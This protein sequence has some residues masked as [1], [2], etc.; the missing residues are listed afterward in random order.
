MLP[1]DPF[2]AEP[3]HFCAQPVQQQRLT[4]KFAMSRLMLVLRQGVRLRRHRFTY[5]LLLFFFF[6]SGLTAW[7]ATTARAQ[8]LPT[9][10]RGFVPSAFAGITGTYTGLLGGRNL[11]VTAGLDLGFKPFFGLL[12]SIEVRGTYP[13][14]NGSI[15]G[16][17]HVE[18]GLRLQKRYGRLRPYADFL[19]GRGELNYQSGGIAVPMQAFRYLQT[20]SNVISP[21]LGVEVDAS[22][23]FAV[24]FDGQFQLWNVPFDPSGSTPNAGH[25]FSFPG[26]I[27]VVYRFN[28]LQHGHAAP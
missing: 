19:F 18:G 2:W 13:V 22:T 10:S 21:G 11:G 25:L 4:P 9:A 16:E 26:T 23:H 7:L 8:S 6:S 28:W 17:E 20:T 14:D 24:L 12:P 5:A 3:S 15:A 27:G 1:L